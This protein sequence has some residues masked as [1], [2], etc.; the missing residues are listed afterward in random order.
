ME[1]GGA[2]KNRKK[3]FSHLWGFSGIARDLAEARE[4]IIPRKW[5]KYFPGAKNEK[6]LGRRW[7]PTLGNYAAHAP[8]LSWM[9]SEV[10]KRT[11]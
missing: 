7:G 6:Y 9:R 10:T 5:K 2:R 3:Y 8:T 1:L 4:A 11:A